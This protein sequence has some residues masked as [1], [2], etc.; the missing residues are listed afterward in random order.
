M[1]SATKA[2]KEHNKNLKVFTAAEASADAEVREARNTL[3]DLLQA[4]SNEIHGRNPQP[5]ADSIPCG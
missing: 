4:K 3:Q 5:V 2:I 1:S